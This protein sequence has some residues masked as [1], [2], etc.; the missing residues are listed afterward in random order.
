MGGGQHQVGQLAGGRHVV[1]HAHE[2]IEAHERFF[3]ERRV[4]RPRQRVA[5]HHDVAAHRVG[6]ARAHGLE[7]R[8]GVRDAVH[9][10]ARLIVHDA[11]F[12]L[13]FRI[14]ARERPHLVPEGHRQ[15][16]ALFLQVTA[17]GNDDVHQLQGVLAVGL[18][19]DALEHVDGG[20]RGRG[21]GAGRLADHL[22]RG[23]AHLAG[24]L[25]RPFVHARLQGLPHGGHWRLGAV[26]QLHHGMVVHV[27][28]DAGGVNVHERAR[29]LVEHKHA[30]GVAALFHQRPVQRHVGPLDEQH[31]RV[32]ELLGELVIVEALVHDDVQPRHGQIGVR[33]RPQSHEVVG[34]GRQRVLEERVD[35]DEL[36]SAVAAAAHLA[37]G[38]GGLGPH[39]V[40][41]P[42][43]DAVGVIEIAPVEGG[44]HAV[45][46]KRLH[47]HGHEANV[48]RRQAV[49]HAAAGVARPTR[50]LVGAAAGALAV[51]DGLGA[52]L[53]RERFHPLLQPVERLVPGDALPLP[54]AALAL[55]SQ[56]PAQPLRVVQDLRRRKPLA[57]HAALAA[58]V[59]RIALHANQ[60]AVL[61]HFAQHPAFRVAL[62]AV[63]LDDLAAVGQRNNRLHPSSF[64]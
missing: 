22:G 35:H 52:V 15:V 18:L 4:L 27:L 62:E 21:V 60:L 9:A 17:D 14:G 16:A 42:E 5:L 61:V 3:H 51:G 33:S 24:A 45:L 1:V 40:R 54:R 34:L 50:P 25:G 48:A 29:V 36:R 63:R 57:A 32:G 58:R 8:R 20:R 11:Q 56:R 37:R 44:E 43:H 55:A 59:F 39:R 12:L 2:Q 23:P 13:G 38:V 41:A 26:G 19:L 49:V 47:H 31:R 46:Q 7:H 6:L 30:L 10:A 53:G 64:P 28:V